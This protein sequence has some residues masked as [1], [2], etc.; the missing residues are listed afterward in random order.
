MH[1]CGASCHPTKAPSA[2]TVPRSYTNAD[3]IDSSGRPDAKL[4]RLSAELFSVANIQ[5]G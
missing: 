2:I 5:E 3:K 1:A 4:I